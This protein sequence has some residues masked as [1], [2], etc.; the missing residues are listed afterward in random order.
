[1]TFPGGITQIFIFV[2][3]EW[4]DLFSYLGYLYVVLIKNIKDLARATL[5]K[6]NK[7][8]KTDP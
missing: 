8:Y 1:M 6:T 3:D 4:R 7:T 5:E 2:C